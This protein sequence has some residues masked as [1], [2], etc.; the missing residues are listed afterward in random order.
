VLSLGALARA[1]PG[2]PAVAP[3]DRELAELNGVSERTI[4][5]A[6]AEAE[7]AGALRR[8]RPAEVRASMPR[9]AARIDQAGGS[10]ARRILFV[11]WLEQA[12]AAP[13]AGDSLPVAGR[14]TAPD[15]RLQT[16]GRRPVAGSLACARASNSDERDAPTN[17]PVRPPAE[18][19][20]P[21]PWSTC[22]R[23]LLGIVERMTSEI[24]QAEAA[25]DYVA[26]PQY[27]SPRPPAPPRSRR[28]ELEELLCACLGAE[29][30]AAVELLVARLSRDLRDSKPQTLDH[31]RRSLPRWLDSADGF[32][33]LLELLVEAPKKDRPARWLSKCL[34]A[35]ED[36]A[37]NRPPRHSAKARG[38]RPERAL[39]CATD[40]RVYCTR[41]V[42]PCTRNGQSAGE[43]LGAP[44]EA[45]IHP[46]GFE[47]VTF[48]SVDRGFWRSQ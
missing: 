32:E 29:A 31:W 42:N 41:E 37:K 15:C 48:G 40:P 43:Q 16:A 24:A 25:P 30:E 9:V 2:T 26:P 36:G 19:T 3:S 39:P 4:R 1:A 5:A 33:R 28:V 23:E 7:A 11:A 8:M 13:P 47:P 17:P 18:E 46:T 6:L 14:Q 34:S 20:G 44:C 21:P 38:S 10:S 35:G 12:G 22:P 27:T 45:P